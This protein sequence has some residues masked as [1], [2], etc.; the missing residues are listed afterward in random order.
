MAIKWKPDAHGGWIASVKGKAGAECWADLVIARNDL[1]PDKGAIA[2]N[3]VVHA[4]SDGAC[5][6]VMIAKSKAVDALRALLAA[7]EASL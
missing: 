3:V 2:W 7:L 5:D 6:G 4:E 1:N